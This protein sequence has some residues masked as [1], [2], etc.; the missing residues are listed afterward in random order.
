MAKFYEAIF[1]INAGTGI[2]L[3]KHKQLSQIMAY[4]EKMTNRVR[5]AL[6]H[7][8]KVEE[9]KMFRGIAFMVDGKM[10]ISVGDTRMMCRIDPAL[11]EAAVEK[12][13][14]GRLK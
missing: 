13:V 7:L 1:I 2:N 3:W 8:P 9:K 6:A 5:A 10:C 12:K 4:N 14:A 11:H